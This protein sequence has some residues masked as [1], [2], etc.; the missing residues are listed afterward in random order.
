MYFYFSVYAAIPGMPELGMV[1]MGDM[2]VH[3]D[4]AQE[5]M[6]D[7]RQA[8]NLYYSHSYEDIRNQQTHPSTMVRYLTPQFHNE[9]SESDGLVEAVGVLDLQQVIFAYKLLAFYID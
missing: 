1:W 6:I 9:S 3:N 5:V 7:P 2:M 4:P 8:D